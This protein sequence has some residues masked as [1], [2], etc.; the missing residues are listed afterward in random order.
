MTKQKKKK[1]GN[2]KIYTSR[3]LI[4]QRNKMEIRKFLELNNNQVLH[5]KNLC[6]TPNIH[7]SRSGT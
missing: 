4:N 6:D 7:N 2:L 1:F 5:D 3:K